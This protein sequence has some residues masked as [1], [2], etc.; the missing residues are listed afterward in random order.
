MHKEVIPLV[1]VGRHDPEE[2]VRKLFVDAWEE[3]GAF[4]AVNVR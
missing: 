4:S 1:Y 2:D 3:I